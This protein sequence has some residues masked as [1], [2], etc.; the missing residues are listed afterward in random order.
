MLA[1][2][3]LKYFFICL[4][5]YIIKE[6]KLLKKKKKRKRKQS[7]VN[8]LLGIKFELQVLKDQKHSLGCACFIKKVCLKMSQNLRKT[9][10]LERSF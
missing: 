2:I 6:K 4:C 7:L 8:N 9:S 10:V 3:T 1:I 5:I